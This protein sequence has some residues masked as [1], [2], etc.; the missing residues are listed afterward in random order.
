MKTVVL[1]GDRS[2]ERLDVFLARRCP[3]LSRS[4]AQRLIEEGLAA[5]NG[6]PGRASQRVAQGDQV[7]VRIPPPQP[8]AIVP[9]AIPLTI[10]YQDEHVMVVDKP[11]GLTVHPAPGH[12]RGTLVNALLALCPDLKD[13]GDALRPGIVHRLD[14]DTSGLLV[15]AKSDHAHRSLSQQLK[16]HEV[17]KTYLTLV[18]GTPVPPEGL[19]DA[20]IARHPRRRKKMAVV[21]GGRAA[22]TRYRLRETVGRH[23]LLEVE[24]ITGR[25]HQIRVH[26]AHI[27]HPLVGD[28]TYGRRSPYVQRQFLHA[29]RL[30]F[31]LPGSHRTIEVESPL[32]PDLREALEA[33]RAEQA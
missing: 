33:M 17:R 23:A 12:P 3:E 31:R 11:A 14:K 16:A 30:A 28:P 13:V 9:E 18:H 25:T 5:L 22:Q 26:L 1:T 19:I 24:P 29:H 27:G 8:S 6:Q 15:V 32:P 21:E 2:G 10:I 20:P 7:V 4:Q